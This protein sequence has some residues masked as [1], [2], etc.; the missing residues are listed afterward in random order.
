MDHAH[1]PY[2]AALVVGLI[3]LVLVLLLLSILGGV[4]FL[5]Q[6]QLPV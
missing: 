4:G 5:I 3:Y 6:Q 1:V 2:A